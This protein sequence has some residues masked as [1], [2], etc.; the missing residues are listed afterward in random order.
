MSK[1]VRVELGGRSYDITIGRNAPVGASI[2]RRPGLK[3][4]IVSDTNVDPLYGP[5]CEKSLQARGFETLRVAVPAGESSKCWRMVMELCDKAAE[6][7]LDRS[8]CI[9]ALGGGVVGD[10][11]GFVAATFLRGIRLI[12]APTSLLA[13]VD[14]SVGGKTGINLKQGKNL[15]GAFHQ[16]VEVAADLSTLKTLP[17]REYVS[18][19]AE[20]VKYGVIRDAKL[21]GA[22]EKNAEKL[23]RRDPGLLEDTVARCCA[24]KAAVVSADE[25]DESAVRAILNF[26]HTFGHALEK[27]T[28]YGTML[29]GEAVSVGMAFAA[30]LSVKQKGLSRE[31][32]YRILMLL[33]RLELP[34][35]AEGMRQ[36]WQALRKGMTADKKAMAGRLRFVLV[37]RLGSAII[38]C[39]VPERELEEAFAEV[40]W[41]E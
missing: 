35:S 33:K 14:S 36:R 38:G 29:H 39:E 17:R 41:L 18:G 21:F 2:R 15:A 4:M 37:E 16:P 22:L 12:Q 32:C 3:A 20:V 8:S 31:E 7:H 6:F 19:L 10:L 1:I 26:G 5:R 30:L 40:S 34:V 25:R 23:L 28:G 11:A 27:S 9:V 13:M 24:I